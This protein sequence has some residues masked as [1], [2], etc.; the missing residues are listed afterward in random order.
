MVE[1]LA[2]SA[3]GRNILILRVYLEFN[4]ARFRQYFWLSATRRAGGRIA[5]YEP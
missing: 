1:R 5:D 4:L 3:R 2:I